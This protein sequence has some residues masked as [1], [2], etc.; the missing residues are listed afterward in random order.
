MKKIFL[1]IVL[2]SL[3]SFLIPIQS[4]S[5]GLVPCGGSGEPPCTICHIFVLINNVITFFLWPDSNIN[6]NIPL[7]PILALLMFTI[8]GFIILTSGGDPGKFGNAKKI[9]IATVV[10][11]LIIYLAWLL[12][13]VIFTQLG[14]VTQGSIDT[15]WYT[16]ECQ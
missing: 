8:G 12:V 14:V 9:I 11:L 3:F 4:Q 15:P 10:G 16:I 1:S 6:N 2:F 13:G 7:V 5:A